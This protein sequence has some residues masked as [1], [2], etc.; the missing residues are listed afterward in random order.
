MRV[1]QYGDKQVPATEAPT[2]QVKAISFADVPATGPS[3][4]GATPAGP[5][6]TAPEDRTPRRRTRQALIAGG[7]AAA[8]LATVG[9]TAAYA[10]SGEVPRGTVVLGVD[11]GGKSRAEAAAA[12][13]AD[14]DRRA[15]TLTAPVTV[16]I[17]EK[18][19]QINPADVGL[20]VDVDA[21]VAA[22]VA[23]EANAVS[24]L[25]GSREVEPVVTVDA[26]RLDTELRKVAG[27]LGP[28]MTIP[29]ITFT[30]TKPT[31]VYPKPGK[32][33]NSEQSAQAL[34]AGWLSGEP[35]T[36]PV[37]DVQPT[38]STE[39]VD[40]LI[41]QLATP[42]V[43]APVTVDTDQGKLTISPAAIAKSL[44]LT[45][46]KNGKITPRV[47]EKK[48]RA[49]ISGQLD[50]V[51]VDP[52]DATYSVKGGKLHPVASKSGRQLDTAV[53]SQDLLGVLPN[54]TGREVKGTLK[55]VGPKVTD[56]ELPTLGIK[57]KVSSFTTYFTGGLSHPRSHN[58][59]LAAEEVDGALVKSGET[60]SLNTHT[61]PRGYAEGYKDAAV[62]SDGK[63]VPGVGGGISQ[64]TTTLFNATYYAGLEDVQHKP[65]SYYFSSYPSVIESTIIY[66]HL[67]F[68]FRNDT[69]HGLIIDTAVTNSSITVSIWST[70]VYD[71][72]TTQWSP[73][74]NITN[75]ETVYLDPGPSCIP[76]SGIDGFTQDAW[77]I[78]R[79][80][81]KELRREKFTWRYE[82]EP[83][84]R[85]EKK[86][87]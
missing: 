1:S 48:L 16:R 80:D 64:F 9:V 46:D 61:G 28:E 82:A 70:K 75:P 60:F 3:G 51:E 4:G 22:S 21:T 34:Q 77:R 38:T 59:R 23:A 11:M 25:F 13:R 36:I 39:E 69:P 76:T 52:K 86:P 72:V 85:C 41:A 14:L 5:A 65:H 71:S 83:R 17:G 54:S 6:G 49:A 67:D 30:G 62:I 87:N 7:V 31:A 66:P 8:V 26:E 29:R 84:Y 43:A 35:V 12:L 81:G 68:K 19:A 27:K 58:I 33:L 79:K 74:R 20:T 37:V 50:K 73:R 2:I 18:T 78:F 45:G 47:D 15:Q 44:V 10:Y 40:R 55:S 63:L 24:R 53:L 56:E 32:G 42:A 57:E